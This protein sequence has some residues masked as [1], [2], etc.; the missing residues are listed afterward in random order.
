MDEV[1]DPNGFINSMLTPETLNSFNSNGCPP[2]ELHLKVDDICLIT[3]ALSIE[4]GFATNTRVIITDINR[5][6]IRVQT[7]NTKKT[8]I[9]PRIHFKVKLPMGKSF[10][11]IR[12]QFP[13]KLAYSMTVNKAQGQEFEKVVL[14]LTKACFTHGHL[15]V[16][17]SRI[18]LP[19]NILI[20][21]K[22]EDVVDGVFQTNNVV[23]KALL[24]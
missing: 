2:H 1:D 18:R 5:Y 21:C 24:F 4:D 10:T 20:Y 14:D 22:P 13:L 3:R 9:V 7:L 12:R 6:A 17:L 11:M 23:Y 19:S 16:G 8:F 15:Y